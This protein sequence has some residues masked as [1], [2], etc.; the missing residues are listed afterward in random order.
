MRAAYESKGGVPLV[1][2]R[3]ALREIRATLVLGVI[4]RLLARRMEFRPGCAGRV[5]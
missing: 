4:F 1:E 3:Y 2:R 5:G